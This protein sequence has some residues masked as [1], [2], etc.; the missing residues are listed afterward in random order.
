MAHLF[1]PQIV[2]RARPDGKR[3]KAAAPGARKVVEES[4]RWSAK[5]APQTCG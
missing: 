4:N 3:C 5:V 1:K 2:R